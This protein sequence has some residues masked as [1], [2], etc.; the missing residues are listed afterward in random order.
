MKELIKLYKMRFFKITIAFLVIVFL[1]S[2]NKESITTTVDNEPEV[3]VEEVNLS[4]IT[5]STFIFDTVTMEVNNYS[6]VMNSSLVGAPEG[7]FAGVWDPFDQSERELQEASYRIY[8]VDVTQPESLVAYRQWFD[9]GADPALE[10]TL[11][12]V[13]YG[14]VDIVCTISNITDTTA[15]VE[16]VGS[17][18]DTAG[19]GETYVLSGSFTAELSEE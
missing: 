11:D 19:T 5:L 3:P 14:E 8:Y 4:S 17:M 7:L 18:V 1:V 6:L 16:L 15:M 2:C 13:E 10:P 12:F 9:N